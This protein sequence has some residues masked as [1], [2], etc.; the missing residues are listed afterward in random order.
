MHG[1]C[2]LWP[3]ALVNTGDSQ[4]GAYNFAARYVR[5]STADI[6]NVNQSQ[7]TK[8]VDTCKTRIVSTDFAHCDWSTRHKPLE[9]PYCESA[10][11]QMTM[12]TK[13]AFDRIERH[14]FLYHCV[15]THDKLC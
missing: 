3:Y 4:E 10:V 9:A 8:C 12:L 2:H 13:R 5:A 7:C 1:P 6:N 11:L 14:S 15:S